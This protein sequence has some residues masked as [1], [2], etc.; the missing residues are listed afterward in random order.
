M[1]EQDTNA[2]SSSWFAIFAE[3]I[4]DEQTTQEID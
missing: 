3:S 4:S 2:Y 1:L